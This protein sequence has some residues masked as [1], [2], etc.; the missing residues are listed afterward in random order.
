MTLVLLVCRADEVPP[1]DAWLAPSELKTQQTLSFAKRRHDWRL[2]RWSAKQALLRAGLARGPTDV[3]I[4]AAKDGA[5]EAWVGPRKIE[6]SLS[7]SHRGGVGAAALFRGRVGCDLEVVEPRSKPF[8]RDFLTPTEQ[9]EMRTDS[10]VALCWSAKESTLKLLRVG[11]RRD[12][13]S[14]EVRRI[15]QGPGWHPL[16]V[17][18]LDD[19]ARYSGWGRR[20]EQLVLTVVTAPTV[21]RPPDL[22]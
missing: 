5:P 19:D 9:S 7:I 6:A 11:L 17:I 15:G 21:A 14:V 18:D 4:E 13:R 1:G 22:V 12:T 2:G 10:D 3:A 16:E 20:L 8:L